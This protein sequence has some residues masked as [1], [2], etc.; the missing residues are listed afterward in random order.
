MAKQPAPPFGGGT[1]IET[2]DL[3][4][5]LEER[6]LAYA[7]ST[8][9]QRAL[10]D[11]RDGLKPVHRRLL[12]AM[13]LLR[14]DPGQAF[15]KSARVVGDVIG[16]YHPHGDQSV[17]DALVR[18][19]QEF[20]QRWT[21]VEGQGNFGNVDGDNPAAM[22]YT[23]ARLTEV[24]RLLLDGLDENAVDFRETYDGSEEEPIV[25]PAAFPN[26]LANG[27]TGIAVGMATSIPPHNAAELLDAAIFLIDNPKATTDDILHF[28]PGPDFPTGGIVVEPKDSIAEAYRTGRGGFRVRSKWHQEDAGR[29]TWVIVVTEIPW[30]VPKSRL[31]EQLASMVIDRKVPILAD[32]RDE[33]ADDIRIVLEP[34]ARTVDPDVLMESLFKLTDLETRISLNMNVLVK[35]KVP[36]VLGLAP[37]LREWL[38]HRREVVVRRAQFRLDAIERRLEVLGG[39]L[40]AFLNIDEVIRIIRTKD[41]PK[42]ELIRKYKITEVQAEAILNIRLRALAKLEEIAIRTE[43]DAL[44]AER[45]E[46]QKLLGSEARQWTKVKKEIAE[47]R[48]TFGPNTALGKRRSNFADAKTVT[49]DFTEALV[50][51][52][53][54]T[55]IVSNMNW[56]RALKGHVEDVSNLGF[57]QGDDL[58]TAFFAET[59]S[60]ILVLA[61][62]GKVFTL[63]ASKLPGGRGHGEPIRLQID[64]EDSADIAQVWSYEAGKKRLIIAT[65]GRGF[66]VGE[67]DLLAS[68]KK[69]RNVLNVDSPAEARVA[70]PAE[71]DHVAVVGENRK[72]VVFP[73]T[74]I[75]EMGRGKGVRLQKYKDGSTSDARV[76]TLK[77]GLT[78]V[79]SSGRNFTVDK[80]DLKEWIGSR[81]DAGRLAPK[82]FP[83]TNK[84]EPD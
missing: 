35:G 60:K 26:L 1:D 66:V 75:P 36:Q 65:D 53:P 57:K 22:R 50:E 70:V 58:K 6:Y 31:I 77:E 7:L 34:R 69:G 78:W 54:I 38:D 30:L 41:D 16:K 83:R 21:L 12:Y 5:A 46:I 80:G 81:A 51:R 15:K 29:G 47:V 2:V 27:S 33:S 67:D 8:I 11:A 14:L 42:A 44:T 24:A 48:K 19:A 82:G 64:L 63:D 39:L 49:V 4:S 23:E 62:N 61:T 43:N 59:T 13:R 68:T 32:V 25:L 84:F 28:I 71:G 55:V 17:Y 74:Q 52:E 3:R 40:I 10:P 18:L 73:L 79:D 20:A 37:A 9:T 45:S 76:F 56:I 72:M